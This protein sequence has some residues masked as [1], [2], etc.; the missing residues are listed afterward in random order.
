VTANLP[1]GSAIT[2]G[3]HR[4]PVAYNPRGT[5]ST[6]LDPAFFANP[7]QVRPLL[8]TLP[9]ETLRLLAAWCSEEADGRPA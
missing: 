4:A 9:A 6:R 7:D 3:A 5:V 8:R 2:V 1:G